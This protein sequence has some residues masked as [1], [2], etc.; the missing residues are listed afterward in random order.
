MLGL[1]QGNPGSVII[2][3]VNL[4]LPGEPLYHLRE[5]VALVTGSPT[6][7]CEVYMQPFKG[8][9]VVVV[10]CTKPTDG[11]TIVKERVEFWNI[12]VSA[13]A[14]IDEEGSVLV[15][16]IKFSVHIM[17]GLL[18]MR[19]IL[20][21]MD[22]MEQ[23]STSHNA[24]WMHFSNKTREKNLSNVFVLSSRDLCETRYSILE[25]T[26]PSCWR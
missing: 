24:L 18:V 12:E 7:F 10:S 17:Q 1:T 11:I 14:C 8:L 21:Q 16:S 3:R 13:G 23:A 4:F 19:R 20:G 2:K 22:E 6:L 26:N 15:P 9:G 25:M 5:K